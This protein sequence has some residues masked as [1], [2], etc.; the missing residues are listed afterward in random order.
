M[1]SKRLDGL[2]FAPPILRAYG[3]FRGFR[4]FKRD[5]KSCFEKSWRAA[6]HAARQADLNPVEF[7][8]PWE[9][10]QVPVGK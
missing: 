3:S 6:R 9:K 2:R 8:F 7:S 10:G 5:M 1:S 4:V